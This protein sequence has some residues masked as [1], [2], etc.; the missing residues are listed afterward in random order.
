MAVKRS[1]AR[2]AF[3]T[4]SLAHPG[5]AVWVKVTVALVVVGGGLVPLSDASGAGQS[6]VAAPSNLVS[7]PQS[8]EGHVR[9][10]E[11]DQAKADRESKQ[12]AA[13]QAKAHRE[14]QRAES[15]LEQARTAAED[16]AVAQTNA[17]SRAPAGEN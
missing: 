12:A 10:A 14:E 17:E 7:T 9:A 15:D 4:P 2:V 5:V 3:P 16:G 13:E 11:A 6:A 8:P 1:Y